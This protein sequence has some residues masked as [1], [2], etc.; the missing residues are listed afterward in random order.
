ME[1][2]PLKDYEGLYEINKNGDIKTIKRR[3]TSGGLLKFAICKNGYKTISLY[4]NGIQKTHTIHTLL[5]KQYIE[6]IGNYPIIDHINRNRLDNNLSNLR[7]TTYS[8]NA[9]N[10]KCKGCICKCV[11]KYK[12]K[13]YIYYRVCYR[14]QK[15]RFKTLEEAEEYLTNLTTQDE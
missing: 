11:D 5:G 8:I 12:D 9:E 7:W 15:K 1:F 10:R 2:E 14:K 3:G 13:E 4:K 6:N